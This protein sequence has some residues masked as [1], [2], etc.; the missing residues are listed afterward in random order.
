MAF[1]QGIGKYQKH[2]FHDATAINQDIN[3]GTLLVG[4]SAFKADKSPRLPHLLLRE[5]PP[6]VWNSMALMQQ[7]A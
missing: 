5:E 3:I 7:K 6:K 1:Y 4:Q 2:M